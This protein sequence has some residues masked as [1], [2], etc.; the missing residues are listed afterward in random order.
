MIT[1]LQAGKHKGSPYTAMH[2]CCEACE[3]LLSACARGCACAGAADCCGTLFAASKFAA[4]LPMRF[5][6]PSMAGVSACMEQHRQLRTHLAQAFKTSML[7][8]RSGH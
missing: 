2:T 3:A 1:L 7:E 6:H 8:E 4:I 5:L